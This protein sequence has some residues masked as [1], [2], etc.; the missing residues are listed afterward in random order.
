MRRFLHMS[1]ADEEDMKSYIMLV[2][3]A[4]AMLENIDL[5]VSE[6]ILVVSHSE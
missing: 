1:I 6:K 3:N 2:E 5:V 4:A